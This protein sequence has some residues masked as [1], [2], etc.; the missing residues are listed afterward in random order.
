MHFLCLPGGFARTSSPQPGER[1]HGKIIHVYCTTYKGY[2]NGS[3]LGLCNESDG[4]V[5]VCCGAA[6]L[7]GLS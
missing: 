4:G 2:C 3:I 6:L 7:P 5:M 1:G